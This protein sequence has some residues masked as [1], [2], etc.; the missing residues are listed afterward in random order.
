MYLAF[1]TKCEHLVIR[2]TSSVL[3][4]SLL[5]ALQVVFPSIL[6]RLK[7]SRKPSISLTPLVELKVNNRTDEFSTAHN[8]IGARVDIVVSSQ[9]G[10]IY[11]ERI[12]T[13]SLTSYIVTLQVNDIFL[14]SLCTFLGISETWPLLRRVHNIDATATQADARIDSESIPTFLQR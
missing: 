2:L 1:A 4:S 11:L 13:S 7:Y 3:V 14:N 8:I 10:A 6:E 12:P 9:L 5:L